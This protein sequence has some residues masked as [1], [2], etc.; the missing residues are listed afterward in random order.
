LKRNRENEGLLMAYRIISFLKT[1]IQLTLL[2]Y[3]G[4][5]TYENIDL[6][7]SEGIFRYK[8]LF[9]TLPSLDLAEKTP[10]LKDRDP[11]K[12]NSSSLDYLLTEFNERNRRLLAGYLATTHI[13]GGIQKA[14]EWT[15]LDPKTVRK[16]KNE[17]INRTILP[18]KRIRIIGGGRLTKSNA[19]PGYQQEIQN[20]ID[21]DLA[22]DPMGQKPNWI[23]KTLRWIKNKM[24]QKGIKASPS[25]IRNSFKKVRISLKKNKKREGKKAHP[26]REVQFQY[27]TEVKQKFQKEGFPIIS[28]DTKKKE[29]IGNFKNDGRTWRKDAQ[30]VLDHDFPSDAIGK[31]IPFGV[32]DLNTNR[33]HI[34]CG[35]SAETSE[36]AVDCIAL[37][38]ENI[39][40]KTYPGK[41]HLLILSDCGGAN[42]AK[43]RKWKVDLQTKIADR[44]GISVTVC[45]YP[46]G[47]SKYNPIEHR[48]FS[49]IS[50]NWEGEPLVSYDKALGYIQTTTTTKGLKVDAILIEKVY[51][52]GVKVSDEEMANINLER[53]QVCPSWNYKIS[54]HCE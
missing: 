13:K 45:H 48:V 47:T 42:G 4:A 3:L 38:W 16:G 30:E 5:I 27:L 21:N 36:F 29:L 7:T 50:K 33:A 25:T 8:Q 10:D 28:I 37:W 40:Q 49:Y 32:Y 11:N 34:Y 6:R 1:Y 26:D 17:I 12:R 19:H 20:I 9:H 31:L 14:A 23:R 44:F 51:Q 39:G 22:G 46:A 53:A 35:I 54:P 43:R 2:D 41:Q 24:D 15:G 18:K 52:K